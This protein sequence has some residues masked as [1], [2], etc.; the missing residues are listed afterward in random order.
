MPMAARLVGITLP[1]RRA[2]HSVV[3]LPEK[4][5]SVGTAS[6]ALT[7]KVPLSP[8]SSSALNKGAA[9]GHLKPAIPALDITSTPV[10]DGAA[11]ALFVPFASLIS[12]D[13]LSLIHI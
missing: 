5:T 10:G 9:G 3:V 2:V 7:A 12:P 8:V 13:T 1:P 4:P 6:G 11:D